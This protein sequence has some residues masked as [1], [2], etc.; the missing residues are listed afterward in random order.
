[1]ANASLLKNSSKPKLN[2]TRRQISIIRK[3]IYLGSNM[4]ELLQQV[5]PESHFYREAQ[6]LSNHWGGLMQELAHT[7]I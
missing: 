3:I 5:E 7:M 6:K 4:A 1:M 2:L